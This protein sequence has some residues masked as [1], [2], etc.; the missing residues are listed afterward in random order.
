MLPTMRYTLL[1]GGSGEP[2]K[3]KPDSDPVNKFRRFATTPFV[4][5]E[6]NR[7]AERLL[8]KNDIGRDDVTDLLALTY[9]A[10]NYS[11]RNGS[12]LPIEIQDTYVRLD[13]CIA[14]LLDILERKVGLQNVLFC[15][16]STGYV[17]AE[18][19]DASLYR[20]PNGEFY[21]NRCAT[22]LNMYL[23]ATYGEGQYVEAYHNLHIYLNHK[24]IEDKQ[25]D[26]AEIQEKA[27]GF[28]MQFSGVSE[29]YSTHQLLLGS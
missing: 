21:L 10:G 29:V 11:E 13:A 3:H 1:P 16:A 4:N 7:M 9:Y 28:L 23:M 26:L 2:F 27:A 19:A 18:T 17:Q 12:T 25:L 8:D 20:I 15:L 6:V 24:L 5:E 14:S 22:L